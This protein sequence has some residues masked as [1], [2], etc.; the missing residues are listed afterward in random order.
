MSCVTKERHFRIWPSF[1][2]SY[3]MRQSV[4]IVVN[5][6]LC[7]GLKTLGLSISVPQASAVDVVQ[8]CRCENNIL[9]VIKKWDLPCVEGVL[10]RQEIGGIF[11]N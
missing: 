3:S 2:L 5:I 8:S 4:C 1:T 11:M 10:Y 9:N 7:D 6:M